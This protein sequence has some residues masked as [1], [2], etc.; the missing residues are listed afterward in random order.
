MRVTVEQSRYRLKI[1]ENGQ[2]LH[3]QFP[4]DIFPYPA[5]LWVGVRSVVSRVKVESVGLG[6][7]RLVLVLG[8][9]LGLGVRFGLGGNVCEGKYPGGN[10]REGNV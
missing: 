4:W 8:L 7:E 9:E 3:R 6:L 10:V 5:R 1:G 2:F